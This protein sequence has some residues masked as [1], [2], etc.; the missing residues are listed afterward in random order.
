MKQSSQKSTFFGGA[1]TLAVGIIVVKLIGAFYKIPLGR[2]LGDVGFG[3]F[4]NAYA[5]F[6]LLLM[7]STAGL[8][9]AMSK[10][11]SEANAMGRHN[12]VNRVFKVCLVTFLVLGAVTT[13]IMLFFAQPLA[14]LQGDS[15]A[16]PAI[17]AMAF[18]PSAYRG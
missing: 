16:A 13:A 5:V 4:N 15:M 7:V 11:I 12:Q 10:T 17:R 9:V 1:A 14:N 6:N 2:I 18:S 3:H 8:P